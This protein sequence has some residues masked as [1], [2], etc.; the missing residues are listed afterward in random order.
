MSAPRWQATAAELASM[1]PA[2]TS[3]GAETEAWT[4]GWGAEAVCGRRPPRFGETVPAEGR[5]GLCAS[6][7]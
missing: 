6:R 7:S 4:G 1:V 5:T 3:A 2:E